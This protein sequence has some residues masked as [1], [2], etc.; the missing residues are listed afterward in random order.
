MQAILY[1]F[2]GYVYGFHPN[3]DLAEF[4]TSGVNYDLVD[5]LPEIIGNTPAGYVVK[6][7]AAGQYELEP[8]PPPEPDQITQL[9]LALTELAEAYEQD[10]TDTQLALAELAELITGGA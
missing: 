9:Q 2:D 10:M 5:E 6:R 8:L 4:E 3:P 7:I 1:T